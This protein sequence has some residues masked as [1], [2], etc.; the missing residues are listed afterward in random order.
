MTIDKE[1]ARLLGDF[2]KKLTDQRYREVHIYYSPID[3]YI[4]RPELVT[5]VEVR[6]YTSQQVLH[7]E[8]K[9]WDLDLPTSL[10]G[11]VVWHKKS[12]NPE[13]H[14]LTRAL[15]NLNYKKITITLTNQQVL[16]IPAAQISNVEE[17]GRTV[18]VY[19]RNGNLIDIDLRYVV[20]MK[21]ER[22]LGKLS[23]KYDEAIN[24]SD[25]KK[26]SESEKLLSEI[27][28]KD[29]SDYDAF[30]R[31]GY[32]QIRNEK[33]EKALSNFDRSLD[34]NPYNPRTWLLR[35]KA[36]QEL[37]RIDEAE[38]CLE[39]ATEKFPEETHLFM[40]LASVYT[41]KKKYDEA[42]ETQN[43]TLKLDPENFEEW[44]FLGYIADQKGDIKLAISAFKKV[45][46]LAP[47]SAPI[48]KRTLERL[49]C[50]YCHKGEI[51]E[52]I[53]IFNSLVDKFPKHGNGY[54]LLSCIY[55]RT[56][57]Y[58]QAEQAA[59]KAIEV[60]PED[61]SNWASLGYSIWRKDIKKAEEVCR[62]A[63]KMGPDNDFNWTA[64][65]KVLFVKNEIKEATKAISKAEELGKDSGTNMYNIADGYA[66][67][68]DTKK[69]LHYLRKAFELDKTQCNMLTDDKEFD[70]IRDNEDFIKL[71]KEYSS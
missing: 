22:R 47:E 25:E 13:Q 34:I 68:K 26:W 18:N 5:N 6:E 43:T 11:T 1:S 61:S 55:R 9:N 31:L 69:V 42:I 28:Q 56:E 70:F 49:G 16:E 29:P 52:A 20:S 66:T 2:A 19:L 3:Y 37:D 21:C 57:D 65:A 24:L 48:Y 36:L 14:P 7:I 10:I 35:A 45:L 53:E 67:V 41:R 40:E 59:R 8:N 27:T 12:E 50:R 30:Y 63:V 33:T 54:D 60:S 15:H 51:S 17:T 4:I 38:S 44:E 39:E 62:K 71:Q 58:E 46:K 23:E 32:A 64:L